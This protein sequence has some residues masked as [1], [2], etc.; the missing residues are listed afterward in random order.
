MNE[1]QEVAT[2]YKTGLAKVNDLYLPMVTEQLESNKITLS[3]YG[4]TCVMNAIG[5]INTVLDSAGVAWGD[6]Q[7]DQSNVTQNLITIASLQLN[8]AANPRECYFQLRNVSS[9]G[10]DGKQVWKKKS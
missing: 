6:A 10:A 1:K 2:T 9:K 4:K 7:L 5:A 8:P 3:E